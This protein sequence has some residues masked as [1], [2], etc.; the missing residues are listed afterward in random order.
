MKKPSFRIGSASYSAS[1]S[2]DH[3]TKSRDCIKSEKFQ[4]LF[5]DSVVVRKDIDNKGEYQTTDKGVRRCVSVGATVTGLHFDLG[6]ID[7][8]ISAEQA[9]SEANLK[10]AVRWINKTFSN[11]KTDKARSPIIM[12]MQRLAEGD[13]SGDWL[14]KQKQ[15]KKIKHIC[16]PA[17]DE[18]EIKPKHL[19]QHYVDGLMN[20]WRTGREVLAE[21]KV[22]L[23]EDYSGQY[24]QSPIA[25]GGNII[26][27]NWFEIIPFDSLGINYGDITNDFVLDTAMTKKEQNDPSGCLT[28]FEH[29]GYL[30]ILDWWDERLEFDPLIDAIENTAANYGDNYSN[31]YV[32]PKANGLSVVQH[33][34]NNTDLLVVEYKMLDGD[35][36]ARTKVITRYLRAGK[37][38]LIKASWNSNFLHLLSLFPRGKHDEAVDCLV[39]AVD[40]VHNRPEIQGYDV[41]TY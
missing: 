41:T 27:K 8:G 21:Q 32:E 3:A 16:L 34:E 1:L 26:K 22:E 40:I 38:K 18:Y 2:Q 37:V 15:G 20:P 6:I 30:Y 9:N 31:V 11:R 39:M 5:G 36:I 12:V 25:F 14:E 35:K 7:D 17:T 33:L 23:G 29:N 19:A 13:P 4:K 10:T 28:F 24:G